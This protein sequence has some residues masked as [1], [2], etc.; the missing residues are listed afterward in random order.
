MVAASVGSLRVNGIALKHGRV[1]PEF[2][3]WRWKPNGCELP[4][5]DPRMLD[6]MLLPKSDVPSRW[7]K[8]IPIKVNVLAWKISMD[9]LP[10]RVNLHRRGVQ[11]SPISCPICCEALENL[12]HL[13]FCCDLAKDIAR[14]I[15][16]W[17]GL[18]WNPVDSYRSWLSWFNLVQLQSSSK[19]VLE[20][21][22][23]TSW[24]SIWSYRNHLLFSDSNPRK[25]GIFEDIVRRS[26]SWEISRMQNEEIER[27]KRESLGRKKKFKVMDITMAMAMRADGHPGSHW[28]RP[29][30]LWL[31]IVVAF[32]GRGVWR[33]WVSVLM[34]LQSWMSSL[35][36]VNGGVVVELVMDCIY[37]RVS[38]ERTSTRSHFLHQDD[39][40][41]NHEKIDDFISAEIPEKKLTRN[42]IGLEMH[43][44]LPKKFSEHT[45][46][47]SDGF[48][49]YKRPDNG[50]FI[51]KGK[52]KLHNGFVVDR[53]TAK[54]CTDD[55][56]NQEI[57]NEKVVDE[58]K[59][60][61]DCRYLSA[62][63]VTWRILGYEVHY[64]VERLPFHLPG[65]QQV[66]YDAD[67]DIDDVLN[68]PSVASSKFL[69][70]TKCNKTDDKKQGYA[71]GRIHHVPPSL[72]EAYYLRV[73]LNKVK[74]KTSWE[75]IRT[76]D[77][78]LYDSFRDACFAMG[79]L[80]DD[81]EYIEAIIEGYHISF[82][83]SVRRLFV[84]L[85]MSN[86]IA[87]PDHTSLFIWDEAPM[88]YRHCFK[89]LDRSL[90]NIIGSTNPTAQE[91]PFG[92]KVIVFGG[93]FRQILHVI[94]GGTRQD[95]VHASLN[96]SYIWDDCTIL[97]LTKNMRLREGSDKSN[98]EEIKEFGDWILKM[99]DGRFGGPND[100][101][102]TVDI[103]D[104]ILI[105]DNRAILA[106]TH[107]VV[108]V[109][110][111]HL[112]SQIPGEEVVY[113]SSDGICE[114]K[115]VDNTYT[116]SLYFPE[117]LNGLKL[118]GIPNHILA[119]KVGAPVMLLRNIDQTAGLCNGTRL[120][121]LKLGEHV[122]EAQIM[123]GTNVRHTT[124]ITRLKLS[125]SEKRLSL[126]INRRQFLLVVCFAMTINKS[127]G[128]SLSNI[129][130]F[131]LTQSSHMVN[132]TSPCLE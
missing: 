29:F 120:M 11:V 118:S 49:V 103:Q 66:V 40:L 86:S 3:H 62:C 96:L 7:V 57:T 21:V 129:G 18:V 119:L 88:M 35:V 71:V 102:A 43:K 100:G 130:I 123:T 75:E 63:E 15:C 51:E 8:Q 114:S 79:L 125:P 78:K 106:P 58:I 128:Q 14:S 91:M 111:D 93:D 55:N 73:L 69:A 28:A 17:W 23:Y 76:A 115:C 32:S 82:G 113:Y 124:I 109:I 65:E 16:N 38:K 104:D 24:W 116:E 107:E 97:E 52:V 50:R 25:D 68:K 64:N 31:T 105:L 122:I 108:G 95:V 20:G 92:G 126:K 5:F 83:D 39:K 36:E 80:D 2:L 30:T 44:Q 48:P 47:D 132:F 6:D 89:A 9:R 87:R 19:Q 101:E 13:L 54:V 74:G 53:V 10:T 98:I 1:D 131:F 37:G 99:G 41:V 45:T 42:F 117:V 90:R 46:T 72:G 26:F 12:D 56:A 70:W 127:Q 81:K 4:R 112:L 27:A 121:I 59:D 60:Y 67:A 84:M 94:L 110:N 77:G 34:G 61:Y 85:L 33:W 22:F